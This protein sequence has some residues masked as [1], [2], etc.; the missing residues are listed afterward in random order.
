[1]NATAKLEM[2][3]KF[4][5]EEIVERVRQDLQEKLKNRK[6]P[7][8]ARLEELQQKVEE[9]NRKGEERDNKRKKAEEERRAALANGN[10]GAQKETQNGSEP[11]HTSGPLIS[12]T[13]QEVVD[14]T[15][16]IENLEKLFE[17]ES[18]T[19]KLKFFF[20]GPSNYDPEAY[21]KKDTFEYKAQVCIKIKHISLSILFG[22]FDIPIHTSENPKKIMSCL[23]KKYGPFKEYDMPLI[24]TFKTINNGWVQ[25]VK[26]IG[27]YPSWEHHRE[28][29]STPNGE[30]FDYE[31][32][33]TATPTNTIIFSKR[34]FIIKSSCSS[35]EIQFSIKT[36]KDTIFKIFKIS[37]IQSLLLHITNHFKSRNFS[38]KTQYT[39]LTRIEAVLDNILISL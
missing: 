39:Q 33:W 12:I 3:S 10:P 2:S 11:T 27:K 22:Y 16:I 23:L 17:K 32:N 35:D 15:I 20:E 36:D 38:Y 28:I 34:V 19:Y 4:N 5:P 1:L 21:G 13:K 24:K 25:V 14:T 6:D 7:H 37:E 29:K 8:Q 31:M 9:G 26:E 18:E 30:T